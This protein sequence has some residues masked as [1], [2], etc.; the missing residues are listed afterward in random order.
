MTYDDL[1]A[2]GVLLAVLGSTIAI[3][4]PWLSRRN[5]RAKQRL[6]LLEESLQHPQLD[7]ETRN[8][9]LSVLTKE[10]DAKFGLLANGAL[11]RRMIFGGGWLV[12]VVCSGMA[13][14]SWSGMVHRQ[15][16]NGALAG[17]LVG[18]AVSSLPFAMREMSSRQV[19]K[20]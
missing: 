15:I 1:A 19:A 5:A 8:Q 2:I 20:Q 16:A 9:I 10:H 18:L 7:P 14:L 3:V 4:G 13:V 12:F 17:A 6:D 11:W